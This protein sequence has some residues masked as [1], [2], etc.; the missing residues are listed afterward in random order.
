MGRYGCGLAV[1]WI[2]IHNPGKTQYESTGTAA[3]QGC[4]HD[5]SPLSTHCSSCVTFLHISMPELSRTAR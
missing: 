2:R 3:Q 1:M 4:S 5:V